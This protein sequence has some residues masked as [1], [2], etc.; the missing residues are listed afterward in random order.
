MNNKKV[1]IGILLIGIVIVLVIGLLKYYI[2]KEKNNVASNFNKVIIENTIADQLTDDIEIKKDNEEQISDEQNDVN[3]EDEKNDE[4]LNTSELENVVESNEETTEVTSNEVQNKP[5]TEEK[6]DISVIEQTMKDGEQQ[7]SETVP[8]PVSAPVTVEVHMEEPPQVVEQ[9]EPIQE[10]QENTQENI[11]EDKEMVTE[12]SQITSLEPEE[13]YIRN[14]AMINRIM[15]VIKNNESEYMK[16]YGYTIVVD[17]SIKEHT[18]QFTFTENRVKAY[19]THCFGTIKIYA[20]DYYRDG[21]LIMT[22]CYI[23]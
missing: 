17:E 15:E 6:R 8:E 18:N 23:F 9:N 20:E 22:E 14:D 4:V 2:S 16:N 5:V 21:Q 10:T 7:V 11:Q 12:P 1:F 3:N 19:I 13:K